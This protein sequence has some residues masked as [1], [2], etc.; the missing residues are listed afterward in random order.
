MDDI[1]GENYIPIDKEKL[2]EEHKEELRN[3]V[4]WFEQEC[5]NSFTSTRSG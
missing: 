3:A 1:S 2:K 5:L 4:D